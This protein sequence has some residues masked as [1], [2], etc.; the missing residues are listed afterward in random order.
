[1]FAL[2][3]HSPS[4]S[5]EARCREKATVRREEELAVRIV[6]PNDQ[7]LAFLSF[8]QDLVDLRPADAR[9]SRRTTIRRVPTSALSARFHFRFATRSNPSVLPTFFSIA[10]SRFFPLLR[11][12]GTHPCERA[13]ADFV[14]GHERGGLGADVDVGATVVDAQDVSRDLVSCFEL[15]VEL[16]QELLE[17]LVRESIVFGR[18]RGRRGRVRGGFLRHGDGGSARSRPRPRACAACTRCWTRHQP[19]GRQQGRHGRAREVLQEAWRTCDGHEA[20]RS[21]EAAV[22]HVHRGQGPSEEQ[23]RGEKGRGWIGVDQV[24]GPRRRGK[25]KRPPKGLLGA[26]LPWVCGAIAQGRRFAWRLEVQAGSVPSLGI[27]PPGL[28]LDDRQDKEA[29]TCAWQE[30]NLRPPSAD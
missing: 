5:V 25:G 29:S 2:Q 16:V 13:D 18:R 23:Y 15:E 12:D 9:T 27:D 30:P 24:D 14:R 6:I 21:S 3:P 1:M 26:N 28:D 19:S 7:E 20:R 4:S 10:S 22:R 8:P 11:F 17:P